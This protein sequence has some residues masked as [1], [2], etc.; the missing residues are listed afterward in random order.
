ML[1]LAEVLLAQGRAERAE[2]LLREAVEAGMIALGATH[3]QVAEARSALGYSLTRLGRWKEAEAHLVAG[4][5]T[6]AASLG[7]D[8]PAT[9]LAR[10][11]LAIHRERR[12][13]DRGE[14]A[15]QR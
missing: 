8:A 2:P 11:R 14:L 13:R 9:R 4:Y 7:H 10:E 1:G 12:T 15:R 6:L 5:E 3:H